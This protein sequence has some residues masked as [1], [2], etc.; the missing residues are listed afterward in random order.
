MSIL[1]IVTKGGGKRNPDMNW[2]DNL[3]L[4]HIC[5]ICGSRAK[6]ENSYLKCGKCS[7]KRLFWGRGIR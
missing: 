1:C 5:P 2:Q 4:N 6:E 3:V 7:Y